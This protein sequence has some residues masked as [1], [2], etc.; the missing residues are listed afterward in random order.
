MKGALVR[1][2]T[3]ITAVLALALAAGCTTPETG[4][5]PQNQPPPSAIA[6]DTVALD[7]VEVREY[8]G[9]RLDS[10]DDFRENSIAGPQDVDIE[11]Y[12][13]AVTG[14]VEL[15]ASYAYSEVTSGFP[16]Y[17]KVVQLDC[18]EGW[19]ARVLWH[20]VLVRDLLDASRVKPEA[21]TVIFKAVDGFS[22]SFP[23]SYFDDRDILLAFRMNGAPLL[24]ERGFPFQLVAEDKWGYK[25]CRWVEEV[26]L[27]A[28]ENY[29]GYWESRGYS[30]TG[31]R[32]K[33]FF[34][35]N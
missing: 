20:G 30:D 26:E 8:Q 18:V 1:R 10:V 25:W 21:K 15:P 7:G 12:R 9:A 17:E 24:P 35:G 32:D 16:S 22:T 19:S 14:L 4:G 6:S 3:V 23:V 11:T 28:D 13:L 34:D 2:T 31:D 27:S 33:S 5:P 29:R